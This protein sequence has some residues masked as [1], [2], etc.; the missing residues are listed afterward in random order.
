MA[1]SNVNVKCHGRY[2]TT[3]LFYSLMGCIYFASISCS[4]A[5]IIV[6]DT[7]PL[8]QQ[9]KVTAHLEKKKMCSVQNAH[10]QGGTFTTVN[11]VAPDENGVSHN[12]YKRF[13]NAIGKGH[14]ELILNNT[15]ADNPEATGNPHLTDKPARVILNEVTSNQPSQLYGLLSVAGRTAH[16]IIV[17]PSGITCDGCRF[18][19]TGHVTL[20]TGV[21]VVHAGTLLGY[22]VNRGV[23]HIEKNG[24]KHNDDPYTF[25]DLFASSLKVNGEIRSRDIIAIIGK[26]AVGF[27]KSDE[28]VAIRSIGGFSSDYRKAVNVD[29][30]QFGRMYSDRIFIKTSGGSVVNKGIIDADVV[31]NIL[32]SFAIRNNDGIISSHRVRLKGLGLIDN[33][34]GQIKSQ[35]QDLPSHVNAKEKFAIR[36]VGRNIFNKE[37]GIYSNSGNISMQSADTVGNVQGV[38]KS[39][40]TSGPANISIKSK[41]VNN[42]M[43]KIITSSN[44]AINTGHL[45]NNQ[46]KIVS[47]FGQVDLSYKKVTDTSGVIH[48]GLEVNRTIKPLL[49]TSHRGWTNF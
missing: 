26:H 2:I 45:K 47:I 11:I 25:L 16:V 43:G 4:H 28:T 27:A 9:P 3:I 6:D 46:G 37:G 33:R 29:V 20:T 49:T 23:I 48:G 38:I 36:L 44:I 10:C 22:D 17:N 12:K 39:N 42:F 34:R 7:A 18:S 5:D 24:L 19:N 15:L 32:S 35:R 41:A 40:S 14:N 21:P 8:N 30:G 13:N 1:N 31:V